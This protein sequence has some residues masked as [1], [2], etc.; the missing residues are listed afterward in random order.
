MNHSY[1]APD[2]GIPDGQTCVA[3]SGHAVRTPPDLPPL[4]G[5]GPPHGG[6]SI[7]HPSHS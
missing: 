7:H 3:L 1:F 5:T 2:A 6:A 4:P